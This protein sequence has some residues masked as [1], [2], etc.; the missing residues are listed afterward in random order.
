MTDINLVSIEISYKFSGDELFEES[1]SITTIKASAKILDNKSDQLIDAGY[2]IMHRIEA[3]DNNLLI[4][5]DK[6]AE[7]Y[8]FTELL[9]RDN[10]LKFNND[11]L[12]VLEDEYDEIESSYF[13]IFEKAEIKKEFR[14]QSLALKLIEALI[15]EYGDELYRCACLV[16]QPLQYKNDEDLSDTIL[17]KEFS[18]LNE[19]E[20]RNKLFSHYGKIGF[21]RVKNSSF[22]V[23]DTTKYSFQFYKP[24]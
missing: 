13:L 12:E 8:D 9:D 24:H 7:I 4:E 3:R 23:V 14:G 17:A 16:A 20:S 5:M 18:N 1:T 10:Y 19:S 22:M 6:D 11:V 15:Y 21:K 2:V